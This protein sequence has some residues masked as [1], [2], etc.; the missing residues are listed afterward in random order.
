[1]ENLVIG[2]LNNPFHPNQHKVAV[3]LW[4]ITFSLLLLELG[5]NDKLLLL[6]IATTL[7]KVNFKFWLKLKTP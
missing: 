7:A 4:F 5:L 3:Y 2:I 1:M 6:K